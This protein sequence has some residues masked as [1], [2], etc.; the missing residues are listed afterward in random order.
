MRH[1]AGY[2]VE[3][4][5][6]ADFAQFAGLE[7]EKVLEM[8]TRCTNDVEWLPQTA[9]E[10]VFDTVLSQ[11]AIRLSVERHAGR[12]AIVQTVHG[13]ATVQ[14]GKDL[15]RVRTIIGTG[16]V[17]SHGNDPAA[18]LSGALQDREISKALCPSDAGLFL[19][20]SYILYACGLLRECETEVAMRLAL[21]SLK[22]LEMEV[23]DGV[24]A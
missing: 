19:D 22:P 1:T 12:H 21:K 4:M 3:M 16:G 7:N 6:E 23:S 17:L 5:E 9:D 24:R 20:Q 8:L 13:P 11:M 18:S 2:I 14:H 10:I 15:T